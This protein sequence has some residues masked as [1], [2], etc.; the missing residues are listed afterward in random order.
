MRGQTV[1]SLIVALGLSGVA[2][3]VAACTPTGRATAEQSSSATFPLEPTGAD[4][5]KVPPVLSATPPSPILSAPPPPVAPPSDNFRI[6]D[7]KN[8]IQVFRTIAPSTVFVTQ[9]RTVYDRWTGTTNE[10]P[11]GS[12]SGFVWDDKGH[13][14]TNFHVIEG[15]QQLTVTLHDH[16]TYEAVVVGSDPRKDI[17]VL[18]LRKPP[19]DLTAIPVREQALPLEV[20]QKTLAIGNPFGLDQTLTTGIVSALG[21]EVQGAGGVTIRDMVQTDA[22]IN[23]GNS[24]GP[25]LD[26][27]GYLIG[28]NTAIFS[29]SGA[30]AGIG[31]AV[32]VQFIK[33]VV[34]QIID[35]GK[36]KQ[37]GLGVRIDPSQRIERRFGISGVVVL[38]VIE[39]TPA[40]RAGLVGMQRTRDGLRLGHV[41]VGINEYTIS[42]YDDLYNTLDRF[43]PGDRVKLKVTNGETVQQVE[44]GLVEIQ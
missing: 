4:Q 39:N 12:G 30:S 28:M 13:V 15:A 20:G 2:G 26:S 37:V 34:P 23:P 31:F 33:R 18:K 8:S 9:L 44:M 7:E 42:N 22:A 32:P 25:L 17:A 19:S 1:R 29:K 43:N 35:T 5:T 6:E 10:V 24:G 36:A 16:K 21:R 11:A 41:I 40:A 3:F 14:V 27:S 38:E